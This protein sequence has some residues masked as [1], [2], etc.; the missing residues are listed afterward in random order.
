[1]RYISLKH[2]INVIHE[3]LLYN[4]LTTFHTSVFT[5][6]YKWNVKATAATPKISYTGQEITYFVSCSAY[7]QYVW[8]TACINCPFDCLSHMWASSRYNALVCW[9]SLWFKTK[10]T[11]TENEMTNCSNNVKYSL[12]QY[13]NHTTPQSFYGPFSGTTRVSRCQKR[14]SG[15]YGARED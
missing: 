2:F 5:Q 1:M 12:I 4:T 3:M 9:R 6:K 11:C 8:R 15:L 13:R 14:T 10:C 7:S